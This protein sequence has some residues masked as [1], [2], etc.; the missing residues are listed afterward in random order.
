MAYPEVRL[1]AKPGCI[2]EDWIKKVSKG[3]FFVCFIIDG[4]DTEDYN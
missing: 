2:L 1:L 3:I 4:L